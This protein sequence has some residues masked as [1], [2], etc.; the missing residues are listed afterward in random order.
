MRTVLDRAALEEG[1]RKEQNL[2][3]EGS[4]DQ[5][6][7]LPGPSIEMIRCS[8]KHKARSFEAEAPW[9]KSAD[10]LLG[11]LPNATGFPHFL[12][13]EENEVKRISRDVGKPL[14]LG[15]RSIFESLT[16]II[17]LGNSTEKRVVVSYLTA[18]KS[19]SV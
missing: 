12:W 1:R 11:R 18:E 16:P 13:N 10:G 15:P 6:T 4:V 8:G 5:L 2:H 7:L 9:S 17:L 19:L 14:G 3:H